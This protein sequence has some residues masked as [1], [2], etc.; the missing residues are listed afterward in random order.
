MKIN[1]I[2]IAD[3][4]S[5]PSKI[6]EI[7]SLGYDAAFSA[8]ISND[9]FFPLLLAAEHSERVGLTT[10]ISVAFAR[11]PMT[12]ASLAHDLNQYSG[13]R[14][15]L[16][17][18]SQIQPH[19]TKRF[20]MPWSKPAARMR[21]FVLALRAIWDCWLEG[22]ELDFRGE[23]YHHTLMT[24]M[25]TP[26]QR[27]FPA[28]QVRVA[29]VG[30]LMTEVAGET[31]DG[32]IAHG[33]TSEKYMREVSLPALERGL[34]KAGRS[35]SDFDV[36]APIIVAS[37]MD[38]EAFE[39]SRQVVK[40]QL[41][42]YASTPAYKPVLELHGWEDLLPTLNRLSKQGEWQKMGELISDEILET[43]AIVC[44]DPGQIAPRFAQRYG[45]LIDTWQCTVDLPDREAQ[46][47]LLRSLQRR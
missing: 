9:P 24:P 4:A 22:A 16:G 15:S 10:A 32:F 44:E 36:S 13:G 21:E 19:I 45:D 33:F 8:E 1:A 35:R 27:D 42:F 14:F 47:Q 23:F 29:G 46:S 30:P 20:S 5:V 12:V 3:L 25:F 17:L 11:N 43:F 28:P 26:A 18:G 40:M 38:T 2:L 31:G 37:G 7:E 39:M 34:A 6:R 41:A